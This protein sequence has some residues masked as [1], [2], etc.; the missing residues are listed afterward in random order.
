MESRLDQ[1]S[2]LV[3]DELRRVV[4]S[5]DLPLYSM[6]EH[7]LGWRAGEERAASKTAPR[8]LGALCLGARAASRGDVDSILPAAAAIELTQ[9]FCEIHDDI[10]SGKVEREGHDSVWWKWGPAQAI[11]AG[12]G[13]HALA[14]M[15]LLG[16]RE[17]GF[18]P[19]AVFEAVRILD[20]ASLETCEGR[21]ID[22]EAQERLD[23]SSETYLRMASAKTGSL[24]GCAAEFGALS[25]GAEVKREL[26]GVG[27][28]LGA[29]IQVTADLRQVQGALDGAGPP[30][31]D[32]MNKRKLYPVVRAFEM[33]T[34]AER[35]RLG[36]F[37]FKRVLDPADAR[38]LA[39]LV[40]DIGA[41]QEARSKID[42]FL[43]Q[44]WNGLAAALP[45]GERRE[46]MESLARELAGVS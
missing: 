8:R 4:S 23:V 13:M 39:E 16:L 45:A 33:A 37:Y 10:Q 25:A 11:N 29:A 6:M 40:A 14:R 38:E 12:D 31:D 3:D 28:S 1:Y 15:A 2:L 24:F 20:K 32:M 41:V 26:A 17:R 42:E 44:T 46:S 27:R 7:Q 30:S 22:L 19:E 36:D 34:P 43:A 35:R 9:N 18:D 5:R 21:F